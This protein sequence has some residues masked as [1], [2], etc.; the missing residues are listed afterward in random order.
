VKTTKTEQE[1][2]LDA[3]NEL[4][5]VKVERNDGSAAEGTVKTYSFYINKEKRSVWHDCAD[6]AFRSV[7][8]GQPCKHLRAVMMLLGIDLVGYKFTATAPRKPVPKQEPMH[9]DGPELS[10]E[11]R[12]AMN[13]EN[14][15]K[16]RAMDYLIAHGDKDK[17]VNIARG[18][19]VTKGEALRILRIMQGEGML[20]IDGEVVML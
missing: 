13:N 3:V 18:L 20:L 7:K 17:V 15:L 4:V 9:Y 14:D 2:L 12:D 1:K 10:Q 8:T 11:E 5:N 6:W 19:M 16:T